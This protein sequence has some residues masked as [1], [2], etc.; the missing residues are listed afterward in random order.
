MVHAHPHGGSLHSMMRALRSWVADEGLQLYINVESAEMPIGHI[1]SGSLHIRIPIQGMLR[2]A[3]HLDT[4][5]H[6]RPHDGILYHGTSWNHLKAILTTGCILRSSVQ[7]RGK[8]AIW[9]GEELKRAQMYSPPLE[10]GNMQLQCILSILAKRV[11]ASHFTSKHDGDKQLQLRECWHQVEYLHICERT[12]SSSPLYRK[13]QPP[14]SQRKPRFVW[15]A[16]FSNWDALPDPWVVFNNDL[17]L[18]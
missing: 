9:A 13:R 18:T 11:K 2:A 5:D 10:F 17:M 4:S 12:D 6:G 8:F 14:I 7:T 16:A 15:Q 3:P 1:P